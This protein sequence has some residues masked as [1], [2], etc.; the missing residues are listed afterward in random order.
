[1]DGRG[2]VVDALET[3]GELLEREGLEYRLLVIGGGAIL[4][5][6]L[7]IRPTLDIGVVARMDG[8]TWIPA[9]PLPKPLVEAVRRVAESL[10]LPRK[11]RDEK[12]WL[13]DGPS[14]VM[15]LGPPHGLFSRAKAMH[16]GGLTLLV[17]ARIDLITL[18]F[19]SATDPVRGNRRAVDIE[20]LKVLAPTREELLATVDWCKKKDGR[21]GFME[22][23]AAPVLDQLGFRPSDP[24]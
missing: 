23:H 16:F 15:K 11:P 6:D 3:L 21:E 8:D 10:G 4:L 9:R 1:M 22:L 19:W 17:A 12:D 7:A 2:Q 14:V 5:Q 20:D 24:T 18:K 13:N